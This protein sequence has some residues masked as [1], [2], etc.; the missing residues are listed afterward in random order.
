MTFRS[1][2]PISF[3]GR[4]IAKLVTGESEVRKPAD[5]K[6]CDSKQKPIFFDVIENL[7]HIYSG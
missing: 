6:A 7:R 3:C 5:E 4:T 2:V 1:A